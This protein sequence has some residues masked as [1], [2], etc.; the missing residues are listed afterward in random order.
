MSFSQN[1][2]TEIAESRLNDCC[3]LPRLYGVMLFGHTY[4]EN[5]IS[6][7]TE[8]RSVYNHILKLLKILYE[9]KPE[10][11]EK[12]TANGPLFKISITDKNIIKKIMTGNGQISSVS[13]RIN[14]SNLENECCRNAFLGGVFLSCGSITDPSKSYHLE[15][16]TSHYHLSKD[17]SVLLNEIYLPPKT[18]LRKSNNILYYK[19]SENIEDLL[20]IMDAPKSALEIMNVKILKDL[21]N[22][23]NRVTNCETAN[24]T[25]TVEASSV[26]IDSIKKL[27]K[28]KYF[29]E[30]PEG[31]KE[32]AKIRLKNPELSLKEIGDML[33]PPI[34]KS[35]VSHRLKK[36]EELALKIK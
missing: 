3:M 27:I 13:L 22:N 23:A 24:I 21:R 19:E 9:V 5:E 4:S 28:Q 12:E 30:L 17:L 29:N 1:C 11:S 32:V 20:T 16:E 8:N 26:H 15:F 7:I 18:A 35:G 6:I 10:I 2:K 36:I 14:F 25:K 33:N 31:L 34:S